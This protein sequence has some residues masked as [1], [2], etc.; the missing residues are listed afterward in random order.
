MLWVL[1]FQLST[2][3]PSFSLGN[4]EMAC[5]PKETMSL[6]APPTQHHYLMLSLISGVDINTRKAQL[7]QIT[8]LCPDH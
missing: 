3:L 8:C 2:C 7:W 5:M 1:F 4:N 6:L